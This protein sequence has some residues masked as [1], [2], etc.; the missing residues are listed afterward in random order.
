RIRGDIYKGAVGLVHKMRTGMLPVLLGLIFLGGSLYWW[1]DH[2]TQG[3]YHDLLTAVFVAGVVKYQYYQPIS[4]NQLAKAYWRTGNVAGMLKTLNDPYT[5]FLPKQEYTELRKD[6]EG[7]FGGIGIYLI[8][9]ETEL[10]ITAVVKGSPGQAAGLLQGDRIV[11]VEKVA[12]QKLGV[13][14]AVAK[15]KGHPGTVVEL[16]VVRGDGPK[17]R[18]LNFRITRQNILLPTVEAELRAEPVLGKY[19]YV[20]I[21]QF[22]ETTAKD[23]E[24]QLNRIEKNA[25]CKA[26]ILDLRGNPG[27]ELDAAIQ[28]AGKFIPRGKPVLHIFRRGQ[29]ME[30]VKNET[31]SHKY[32]PMVVLVDGWSA[33]ASEIVAGALK[34]QK[35]AV[36]V[37]TATFGKDLIQQIIELPGGTGVS[38]TVA[39]YLT[40]GKVNIHKKGVNPD[41]V[42]TIPGATD[43]LLQEGEPDLY[44][45]MRK[46]QEKKALEV[47]RQQ[48]KNH[49]YK[50]TQKRAG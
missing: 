24:Q 20:K 3:R 50:H 15:M 42:I 11:A 34:D 16:E 22:A 27:G 18:K 13:N 44:T 2:T 49:L 29:L 36:L 6:T 9:K 12:V 45:K 10:L 32:L 30:T 33:S 46:M 48:V 37:G 14:A 23:L 8:P 35:R 4:L 19:A 39:S 17:Q 28:V 47:L 21:S 25:L 31:V 5:R 26:L 1:W 38:I 7:I 40:S 41:I 43:R